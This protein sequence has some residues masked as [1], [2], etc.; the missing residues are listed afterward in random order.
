MNQIHGTAPKTV[1][2]DN[3]A[4][5]NTMSQF[6]RSPPDRD[7]QR[8]KV[9]FIHSVL[10]LFFVATGTAYITGSGVEFFLRAKL[11]R[12][13]RL[14]L[15][16]PQRSQVPSFFPF[17]PNFLSFLP[18]SPYLSLTLSLFS[19]SCFPLNPRLFLHPCVASL[20]SS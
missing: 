4:Y 18:L 14:P 1:T 17:R 11:N 3:N 6:L 7:P 15:R 12:G 19:P 9:W 8:Y 10:F 2:R 20:F 5:V 13:P 16:L